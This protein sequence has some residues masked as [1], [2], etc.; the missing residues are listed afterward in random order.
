MPSLDQALPSDLPPII[1]LVECDRDSVEHYS[2]CFED[3][4]LWVAITRET[5]EALAAAEE[6]QP[7]LIVT[8]SDAVLSVETGHVVDALKRHPALGRVPVIMMTSTPATPS[9]ADSILIKPVAPS[10]L[11][12]RTRELLAR[13]RQTRD[14]A[15]DLVG[16]GRQLIERSSSLIQQSAEKVAVRRTCPGCATRLE[17]V[18]QASIAGV[19]YDYY[20]WCLKGC[21]LYCFDR[22]R[23]AWVKL[24]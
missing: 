18:E 24:A 2:R 22:S 20:R 11:L 21:G 5:G 3:A 1:L 16:Q 13:A 10:A 9:H 15:R 12:H 19:A 8:D 6:L 14:Q 7:D 17:W 23:A 4:G